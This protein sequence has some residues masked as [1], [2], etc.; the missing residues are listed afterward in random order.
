M[1]RFSSA[2]DREIAA[3]NRDG[4]GAAAYWKAT[5]QQELAENR[6]LTAMLRAAGID[7]RPDVTAAL[8]AATGATT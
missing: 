6:R 3:Y 1:N 7:P 2:L 4:S 5:W 8:A